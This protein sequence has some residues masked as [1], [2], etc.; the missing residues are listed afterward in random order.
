MAKPLNQQ[1]VE[2]ALAELSE[3]SLEN[4]KL[5]RV[6]SFRNFVEAFAFMTKVA[7]LAEKMNHHPDWSN[8]YKT[9]SI[10]LY[11]HDSKGLSDLDLS[12]AREIDALV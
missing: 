9:V 3:W 6:F 4:G 7:L 11:T 1:D 8:V 10:S 12:L 5:H 2:T